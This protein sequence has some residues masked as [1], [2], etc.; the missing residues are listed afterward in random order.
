MLMSLSTSLWHGRGQRSAVFVSVLPPR[1]L[2]LLLLALLLEL[3]PPL[4]LLP[5]SHGA[6]VSRGVP[7]REGAPVD[8]LPG[9][10]CVVHLVRPRPVDIPGGSSA[11]K[12]EPEESHHRCLIRLNA[13]ERV[14][15]S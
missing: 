4:P 7:L 8:A 12:S 11:A 3:P 6:R 13:I 1:P 9:A 10:G 5:I 14:P 2:L 15:P